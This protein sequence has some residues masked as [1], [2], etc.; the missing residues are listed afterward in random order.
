MNVFSLFHT[1]KS[2][3]VFHAS[4]ILYICNLYQC[5]VQCIILSCGNN[6]IVYRDREYSYKYFMF[7]ADVCLFYYVYCY[8]E[9]NNNKTLVLLSYKVT[10][11]VVKLMTPDTNILYF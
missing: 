8:Y 5:V 6:E 2:T 10:P 3:Y 1:H 9:E 4:F 7:Y 11:F